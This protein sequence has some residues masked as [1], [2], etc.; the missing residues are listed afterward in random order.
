MARKVW[1]R[2]EATKEHA[3]LTDKA[4]KADAKSTALAL[5]IKEMQ[6]KIG[7]MERQARE[8][9]VE[10][11]SLFNLAENLLKTCDDCGCL[12][13]DRDGYPLVGDGVSCV[14]DPATGAPS[15]GLRC[16]TCVAA[17]LAANPSDPTVVNPNFWK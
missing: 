14:L 16:R 6:A 13:Y 8:L 11:S 15:H 10:A 17:R 3:R 9:R 7:E 4:R 5:R 2:V 12:L 1:D